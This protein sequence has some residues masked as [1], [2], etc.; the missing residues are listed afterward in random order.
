MRASDT[1]NLWYG[2]RR[3]G[4]LWRNPA[5]AIGFRYDPEWIPG[6]G[7]A[8][9]RSLPL[10]MGEFAPE[11]GI[12]QRWFANL[13]PEGTVR[14]HIVR[15]LKLPNT[16]FDLHARHRAH[17]LPSRLRCRRRTQSQ[18]D[19]ARALGSARQTM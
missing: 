10:A 7:F 4:Q 5:G 1:L 12:A 8:V 18:C 3:V 14:E 2:Q 11:E 6:G 9:S 15:D 17:R 19:H 16:D 13:L